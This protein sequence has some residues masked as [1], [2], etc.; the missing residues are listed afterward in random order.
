[1]AELLKSR[2]AKLDFVLDEG[3]PITVGI[4]PGIG[5]DV[6]LIGVAEK[7]YTTVQLTVETQGGHSST[8]PRQT[9]IGIAAAAVQAIEQHPYPA[10]LSG[11]A[12]D[13]FQW[14][15]PE[16]AFAQRVIFANDW[17]FA[18]LIEHIL[19]QSPDTNA[20]IRTTT[21]VTVM[22]GG[23]KDNVLPRSAR[24]LVNFRSLPGDDPE[25]IV[26]HVREAVDDERV[27]V[28]LAGPAWGSDQPSPLDS[29]SSSGE[30]GGARGV[31]GYAGGAGL[32]AGGDGCS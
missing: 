25:E 9:A 8:P 5:P 7:G 13:M 32:D 2:G 19:S 28:E 11:V 23:V 24:V 15:A 27:K 16:G 6:A 26:E 21:A 31:C 10:R 3:L 22:D 4:V 30:S 12:R 20:L 14:L 17:L 18:P 1:M 29:R